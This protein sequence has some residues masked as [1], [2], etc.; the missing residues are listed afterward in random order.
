MRSRYILIFLTLVLLLVPSISI[1]VTASYEPPTGTKKG[2]IVLIQWKQP[3]G[4]YTQL[5]WHHAMLYVGKFNG[6][7]KVIHAWKD[8]DGRN[9][10]RNDTWSYAFNL[11]KQYHGGIKKWIIVRVNSVD[12]DKWNSVW[13]EVFSFADR[14]WREHHT[15]SHLHLYDTWSQAASHLRKQVKSHPNVNPGGEERWWLDVLPPKGYYGSSDPM[16]WVNR[17]SQPDDH[18]DEYYCTELIWAAYFQ[19]SGKANLRTK[20]T[21]V[22]LEHGADPNSVSGWEIE[23][24]DQTEVFWGTD[25]GWP[26][27]GDPLVYDDY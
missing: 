11:N 16:W 7:D 25:S 21:H 4:S 14:L 24:D 20:D 19:G 1:V 15:G 22:Y 26:K 6:V 13:N 2:D 17:F 23:H 27:F 18:A 3:T 12:D 10:T 5:T 8:K 9:S